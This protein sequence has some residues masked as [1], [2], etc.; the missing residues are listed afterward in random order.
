MYSSRC[1]AR[2]GGAA[3]LGEQLLAPARRRRV[4]VHVLAAAHERAEL[5]A[6]DVAR[7]VG[8]EGEPRCHQRSLRHLLLVEIEHLA[9]H[10]LE[11][12]VV[13]QPRAV[14]VDLAEE[15]EPRR[16]RRVLRDDV[17]VALAHLGVARGEARGERVEELLARGLGVRE[18]GV[19]VAVK[20]RAL[21]LPQSPRRAQSCATPLAAPRAPCA[22]P[23]SA[24]APPRSASSRRRARRR[25]RAAARRG[26]ARRWWRAAAEARGFAAAPSVHAGKSQRG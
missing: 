26:G 2:V 11:L 3:A 13:D 6:L 10:R 15:L 23:Q 9:H 24:C 22:L 18:L 7:I 16:R 8:V 17:D 21:L 1:A 25:P 19:D 5:A 12:G 14:G 20:K 4:A